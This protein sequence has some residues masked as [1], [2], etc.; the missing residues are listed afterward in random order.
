MDQHV[1]K[2]DSEGRY[3]YNCKG[4]RFF[5][6]PSPGPEFCKS[7]GQ[8]LVRE[9]AVVAAKRDLAAKVLVVVANVSTS[10]PGF[11]SFLNGFN[12]GVEEASTAL[13]KFFAAEGIELTTTQQQEGK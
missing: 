11:D 12:F 13:R 1:V 5:Y 3:N 8:P 4:S 10:E 2:Y 7:C 9:T 6:G